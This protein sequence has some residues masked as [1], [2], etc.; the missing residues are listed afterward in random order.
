[1]C[2]AFKLTD[3][4]QNSTADNPMNPHTE[5]VTW[6][7]ASAGEGGC[8]ITA[9]CGGV[10]NTENIYETKMVSQATNKLNLWISPP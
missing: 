1:M 8:T 4:G 3:T 7:S 2:F 9:L 5:R 10:I 6:G